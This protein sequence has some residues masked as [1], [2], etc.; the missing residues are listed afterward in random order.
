MAVVGTLIAG[1]SLS[2]FPPTSGFAARFSLYRMVA[3]EQMP[4]AIAMITAGLLPAL[5][6]TRFAGRAFQ[7]VPVPGSRREPAWP[8]ALV[9]GMGALL[10]VL[11]F[12]PQGMT[13]VSG[14]WADMLSA[15]AV[16]GM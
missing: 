9:I 12:W 2:G 13:Y 3:L 5:A 14:Q 10:L 6:M 11:G 8:G 7:V 1:L 4:W 15:L 16:T